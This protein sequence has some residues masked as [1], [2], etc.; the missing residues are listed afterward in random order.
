MSGNRGG[1]KMDEYEPINPTCVSIYNLSMVCTGFFKDEGLHLTITHE[2]K[3]S[4]V[5]CQIILSIVH[6]NPNHCLM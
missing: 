2:R 4:F 3:G 5:V 1:E 6:Y